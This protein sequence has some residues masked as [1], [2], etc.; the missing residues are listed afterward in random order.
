[1]LCDYMDKLDQ[2]IIIA[3]NENA[4]KSYRE[5][6]RALNVS[7]STISNRVKNLENEGIIERYIPV[8]NQE[9]LGYTLTAIINLKISRG[10]LIEVQEKISKDQ[11]VRAVYDI[12]GE[13][14]SVLIA[15]F[16]DRRDLNGFIKG[17]LS[18]EYVERTN[19]QLVLNIVKDEKRAAF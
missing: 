2:R 8:I 4:R 9:K 3:L 17:V 14:D 13:W 19:T 11:R 7:L 10:K 18:M 16:K 15:N 1:M 12:T 5:M 6:A